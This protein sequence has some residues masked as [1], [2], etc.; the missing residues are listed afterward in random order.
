MDLH[1]NWPGLYMRGEGLTTDRGAIE[2]TGPIDCTRRPL[3]L[4]RVFTKAE[5]KA[6]VSDRRR[7]QRH[8]P[9][10]GVAHA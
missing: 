7:R 8:G 4:G 5:L 3:G 9:A 10:R 2:Q 6:L 1:G